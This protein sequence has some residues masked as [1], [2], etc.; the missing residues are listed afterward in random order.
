[1][2]ALLIVL[3]VANETRF[4]SWQMNTSMLPVGNALMTH[5]GRHFAFFTAQK[6]CDNKS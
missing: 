4:S 6:F 5:F 3:A 2:I 1:L